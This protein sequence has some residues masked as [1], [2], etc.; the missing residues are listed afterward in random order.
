MDTTGDGL[1]TDPIQGT[2]RT[3][4]P[5]GWKDLI[6]VIKVE[7]LVF[8]CLLNEILNLKHIVL[9]LKKKGPQ[10]NPKRFAAVIIRSMRPKIA[11]LIFSP[12]KIVCTGAKTEVQALLHINK[13]IDS[14]REIGYQR[15][16]IVQMK[17]ENLVGSTELPTQMNISSMA[18]HLSSMCN[19]EPELFPGAI[20]RI[21]AI[22]PVTLLV[23]NSG[24][25]V[26]TGAKEENE[27]LSKLQ[28]V[29]HILYRFRENSSWI[30]EEEN[31]EN[32][33]G[34]DAEGELTKGGDHYKK[35]NVDH[36]QAV[37][38]YVSSLREQLNKRSEEEKKRKSVITEKQKEE[39][40]EKVDTD[41]VH[42]TSILKHMP[43][44]RNL[45]SYSNETKSLT[46]K[47]N[48]K[49]EKSLFTD[50]ESDTDSESAD[51]DIMTID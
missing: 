46:Q 48:L 44:I 5:S 24:R 27:A 23:F 39:Y 10:Y 33:F 7:N 15:I 38:N 1:V 35:L 16:R 18:D 21:P 49:E 25:I 19:Y 34:I 11:I 3:K 4:N 28:Q 50:S 14:I 37:F 31:G 6:P 40:L 9:K 32:I 51:V 20:L 41:D 30:D 13:T 47:H 12:G 2:I 29:L 45:N 8:T 26:L 43:D 36:N 17:V 22:S 42:E